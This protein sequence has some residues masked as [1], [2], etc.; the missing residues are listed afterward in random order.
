MYIFKKIKIE[1]LSSLICIISSFVL[2]NSMNEI[3][4]G[5]DYY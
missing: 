1:K 4:I 2:Y 3:N 5:F